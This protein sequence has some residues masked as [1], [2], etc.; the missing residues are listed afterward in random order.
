[1]MSNF[2]FVFWFFLAGGVRVV[3]KWEVF[4]L[5]LSSFS[6]SQ[7]NKNKLSTLSLI[8]IM[9]TGADAFSAILIFKSLFVYTSAHPLLFLQLCLSPCAVCVGSIVIGI[10]VPPKR[11]LQEPFEKKSA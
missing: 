8:N 3:E 11:D 2:I 10:D 5:L 1:M 6:E 7:Q 9:Q 4:I